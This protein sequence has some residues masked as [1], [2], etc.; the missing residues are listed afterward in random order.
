MADLKKT[1]TS[2]GIDKVYIA[3]LIK[4]DETGFTYD[5]NLL[6]LEGVSELNATEQASEYQLEGDNGIV[7]VLSIVTGLD[8]SVNYGVFSFEQLAIMKGG[9]LVE[10]E[11]V[12]GEV[13]ARK[14]ITRN[15]DQGDYFGVIG[16]I[17]NSNTKI[18]IPKVKAVTVEIPHSNLTHAVVAMAAKAIKR[19]SDGVISIRKQDASATAAAISDFDIL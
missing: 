5:S 9:E 14:Y 18:I 2:F 15:S 16:V 1:I 11:D 7:E 12:G 13:T 3:K 17:E 10:T 6:R 19:N 4:D 8:L